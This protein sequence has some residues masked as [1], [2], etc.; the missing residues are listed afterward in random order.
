MLLFPEAQDRAQQEI[1]TTVGFDRLPNL[2]DRDELPYV[3][4]LVQEVL[5]WQPPAPMG[6]YLD[7]V[8]HPTTTNNGYTPSGIPHACYKDDVYRGYRIPKETIVCVRHFVRYE[9]VLRF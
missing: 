1:D 9:L 4:N 8:E 6:D 3:R 7:V 5:R 2:S